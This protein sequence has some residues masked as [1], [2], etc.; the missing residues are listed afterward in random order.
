LG[1]INKG[2]YTSATADI[3]L[4]NSSMNAGAASLQQ[5]V[6]DINQFNASQG[7]SPSS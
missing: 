5:A 2:D 7:S 4:A 1:S 3:T 6:N